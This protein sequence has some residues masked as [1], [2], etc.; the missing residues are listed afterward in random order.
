MAA[1]PE[2]D[3]A[4]II[5]PIPG[6]NP[7][8]TRM[9][10]MIR[11]QLEADRKEFEPNKEDP[12]AAPVP[13]K[14]EWGRIVK[15]SSEALANASKDLET[16]MRLLEALTR[17][18]G[19]AGM[20]QGLAVLKALVENC[21]DYLHPIPDP[22]DGEG[23][24]IRAAA[25][26]W[27]GD[28][29]A[30]AKF[31]QTVR[32]IP[33]LEIGSKETANLKVFSMQDRL[34][35][36]KNAGPVSA[37]E[38]ESARLKANAATEIA[39][40]YQ[41]FLDLEQALVAKL[42]GNAPG[43][44]GL[45]EALEEV[46]MLADRM[47]TTNEGAAPPASSGDGAVDAEGGGGR[48]GGGAIGSFQVNLSGVSTREEAYRLIGQVAD[49]LARIEPHSPIPDLLHRAIELGR[50]PFRRLIK[51]LIRDGTNLSQVYREFGIKEEE[52]TS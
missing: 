43:M 17:I 40:S 4:A 27:I 28:A 19:F 9:P 20:T 44:V 42:E 36:M 46:R 26:N 51:E 49:A 30:G 37:D 18:A 39:E 13:K 23:P 52:V 1:V 24:E 3:V 29:A 21:W 2:L 5:A 50:M 33:L 10:F 38:M 14:P 7:G 11:Q 25:F 45:R 16:A 8:G 15:T 6:D 31:P 32:Q 41:A 34:A 48:Q 35:S 12:S 22:Q 47:A